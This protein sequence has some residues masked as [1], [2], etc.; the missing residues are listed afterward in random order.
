MPYANLS[1]ALL[2]F[3]AEER[4]ALEAALCAPGRARSAYRLEPD[5]ERA[6]LV[7]ADADDPA[8]VDRVR[9]G[10]LLGRTVAVGAGRFPRVA[11]Q[12]P[13]PLDA[14]ALRSALARLACGV[15]LPDDRPVGVETQRV[16][17]SLAAPHPRSR[18]SWSSTP[19]K[20]GCA[21]W[22]KR[23]AGSASR[24]TWRAAHR[25]RWRIS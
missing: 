14:E 2:G 8:V 11:R 13:R 10:G 5:P 6:A 21:R 4:R 23:W 3:A 19:T 20:V 7:V 15:A 1:L 9:R 18:T 16:L 24:R 22:P 25:R 17:E 12:L